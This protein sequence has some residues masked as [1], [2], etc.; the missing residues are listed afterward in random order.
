MWLDFREQENRKEFPVGPSLTFD[1]KT[2]KVSA[3][4]K[5]IGEFPLDKWFPVEVRLPVAGG[6]FYALRIGDNTMFERLPYEDPKY[7]TCGWIGVIGLGNEPA[8]FYIDNLNIRH[9]D[10][11]VEQT[12]Q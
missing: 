10:T 11:S 4:R 8:R 6:A 1:A 12:K 2:S 7:A 3:G 9:A 5:Q